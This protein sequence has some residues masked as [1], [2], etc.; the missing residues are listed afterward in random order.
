MAKAKDFVISIKPEEVVYTSISTSKNG[1]NSAR[2]VIE[3][4]K[5]EY[6]NVSYE[7]EGD[8]IPGFAMDLVG[9]MKS[10]NVEKSGIWEGKEEAFK[11]FEEI[12]KD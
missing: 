10:N 9:F 2:M 4:G 5:N 3:M 6:M 1:Y 12:N 8:K 7:W 11:K